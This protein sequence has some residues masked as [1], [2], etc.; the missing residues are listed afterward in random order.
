MN[1]LNKH[2]YDSADKYM[3]FLLGTF[4]NL[5]QVVERLMDLT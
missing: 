2:R 5:S 3:V 4:Q 1:Q